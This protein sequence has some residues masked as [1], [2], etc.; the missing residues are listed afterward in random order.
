MQAV[1][2]KPVRVERYSDQQR[3]LWDEFVAC[4]KNGTFLFQRD[5]MEYH[6]QRFCDHSLIVWQGERPAAL[7]PANAD[8]TRLVSHA[9]LSYGGFITDRRMTTPLMLRVFDAVLSYCRAQRF[10]ELRYKAVPHIYH[11]APA[12]EDLYALFRCSAQLVGRS[13]ITVI[14]ARERLLFQERR[15]RG[16]RRARKSGL[17]TCP[18]NDLAAYWQLLTE[19]LHERHGAQPTHSFAEMAYLQRLFPTNIPLY[20]CFEGAVML[21]GVLV[22]ESDQVA[23]AQYIA[24]SARGRELGAL[25]LLFEYLLNDV[26]PDKPYFDFGTS[27]DPATHRLNAGL[28]DQKEGFGARAVVQ[29]T[30]RI[31]LERWTPE[32]QREALA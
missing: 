3:S 6:R 29:D 27:E 20:A 5:Y 9:G 12:E 31:D 13:V 16:A 14:A 23:R 7:L 32:Q 4:S 10:A 21:A 1:S 8:G 26:Y 28:I 22:Y 17:C 11:R 18:S 2:E 15:R 30:Y 25:D 24:A 19:T